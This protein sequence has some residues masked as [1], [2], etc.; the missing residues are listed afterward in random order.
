MP[1]LF[2]VSHGAAVTWVLAE[3]PFSEGGFAGFG[4]G[5]M[6]VVAGTVVYIAWRIWSRWAAR[7]RREE[8]SEGR[9]EALFD[10]AATPIIEEDFTEV[11]AWLDGLRAA[12]VEDLNSHLR[13][14]P[15]ELKEQFLRIRATAANRLALAMLGAEDIEE[16]RE[17]MRAAGEL[18]PPETFGLELEALWL[19]RSS[20]EC[21]N[22]LRIPGQPLNRS[23]MHWKVWLKRGV[24]D[25]SRVLITFTDHAE[26]LAT[27]ER[28]QKL[29]DSIPVPAWVF[30]A[31]SHRFLDVNAAA[32]AA[33]G[34]SRTEFLG[35]RATDVR[36]PEDV[37]H[38]IEAARAIAQTGGSEDFRQV[39]VWRYRGRNGEEID[40]EVTSRAIQMGGRTALMSIIRDV[41]EHRRTE[42]ALRASEERFRTL[43]EY[44][45]EGIYESVPGGGFRNAN[46]AFAR[47]LGY[48][49]PH[50][51]VELEPAALSRLYTAPGRR[52]EFYQ[53]LGAG[54]VLKDFESEIRRRDGSLAW[55]SE[56]VRAARDKSGR[57]QYVQ[58]FVSDITAHRHA[59]DSL[60][61][62]DARHRALFEHSPV[63]IVELD[64]SGLQSIF[65]EFRSE[66]ATDLAAH[67]ASVPERRERCLARIEPKGLNEAAVRA[68]RAPSKRL[69]IARFSEATTPEAIEALV[70]TLTALWRGGNW[71]EG[72]M[73]MRCMDGS[74]R[75]FYWRWWMPAGDMVTELR[76]AQLAL[77]DVTDM[78]RTEMELRA[79]E[80]RFR[81]LFEL[82]PVG[83]AEY[84]YRPTMA[85]LERLRSE[86]VT[87]LGTWFDEH[88]A[89]LSAAMFRVPLI[90]AN[91]T[92]LRLSGAPSV[93]ELVAHEARL[94]TPEIFAARRACFLS[95]WGGKFENEGEIAMRA[96]DGTPH[97]VYYRWQIPLVEGRPY[98]ERAQMALLDL[99]EV[100]AA[101]RKL[102][103][104]RERLSV[105]LRAMTEGVITTNPQGIV[106][107][108]NEA[109]CVASGW[110]ERGAVGTAIDEICVL[111]H[112]RTGATVPSPVAAAFGGDRVVN[113]P[114]QTQL[115]RRDGSACLLEGRCALMHDLSGKMLGAVLVFR[116]V[117]ER[118]RLET[119]LQRASKLEAVGLL[120]GGIAHDFNNLLA[121]IMGNL[122]VALL[123]EEVMTRA[124]RWLKEAE[125]GAGRARDLT[126]Q[127]L[128]F[129]KGGEPVRTTVRLQE[130]VKE[131]AEFATHGAKVRCEFELASDLRAADADKGQIGQV[132]QNLVINALQAMPEGGIIR[133][134]LRNDA[135]AEGQ[136]PLPPGD[137]L[138][139]SIADAGA[140][141]PPEY[142]PHIF[143]PYFTTKKDGVGL[144][145]ATVYSIVRKHQGHVTAESEVGRGTAFHVWLPAA[146]TPAPPSMPSRSPFESLHGRILFMDDEDTVRAMAQALLSRLGL[147][148]VAVSTGEAAVSEFSTARTSG[149][150]FD[151]VMMDLTVP[152][153]M[154]GLEALRAM[155][156]IDPNV[157]GVVSSGYS[158]DPVMANYR[159]HGFMAMVPKPYRVDELARTLR[160]VLGAL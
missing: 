128:T 123:D 61:A 103:A 98:F 28:Y 19:G 131:A 140:G 56:N 2:P 148:V 126:Q 25:P 17:K 48:S 9:F 31:D 37:P 26:L 132:V 94:F 16:F 45:A 137:Y 39:G 23:R 110:R 104:E 15:E 89:E 24:P 160:E 77:L 95:A 133:I 64:Y 93:D 130:V 46:P 81:I 142:L 134:S 43:F 117:T 32:V 36:P 155:R 99:T 5:T 69:L 112:E 53:Q 44:A 8:E 10:H 55:I 153:A 84:D 85:W 86:G 145:L 30:D 63:A 106:Q 122:S 60:R 107:F 79:S 90:G 139:L 59:E 58:G 138:R 102:A 71:A 18:S 29:F 20:F 52:E 101:E 65:E 88:P 11:S 147:E 4:T 51:V 57:V 151:V 73:P 120:A 141:I 118:S 136:L 12:G 119:E 41:T 66:G 1:P 70:Q 72:E 109:A 100:K 124:G 35:L 146:K 50:D 42:A 47:L 92:M 38:F 108:I 105:T 49:D 114:P 62:S 111:R 78:R 115:V 121:V 135:V 40:A 34:W 158:S 83:I 82:S 54:E 97:G 68:L 143:D 156:T 75:Q 125:R 80:Q 127:L 27:E 3:T 129:A 144:G 96:M 14:H 33:F 116:D 154:G 149:K 91:A 21:E 150:P 67:L 152:G 22:T 87:E 76:H 7:Q 6:I 157:R 159:Q 74:L 13:S 113:I